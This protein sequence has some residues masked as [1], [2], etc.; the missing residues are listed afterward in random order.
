MREPRA[1]SGRHLSQQRER[2]MS[3]PQKAGVR[4]LQAQKSVESLV[5]L[6]PQAEERRCARRLCQRCLREQSL[7]FIPN[8]Q[9]IC[10]QAQK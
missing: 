6:K 1:E 7:S 10:L 5:P 8:P 9:D 2:R 4:A 3:T